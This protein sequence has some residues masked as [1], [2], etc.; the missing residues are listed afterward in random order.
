[1]HGGVFG[2]II[3]QA[4]EFADLDDFGVMRGTR[5]LV[6]KADEGLDQLLILIKH[7]P[8]GFVGALEQISTS[9]RDISQILNATIDNPIPGSFFFQRNPKMEIP[10]FVNLLFEARL[11]DIPVQIVAPVCPDYVDNY[12][13]GGGIGK[14]AEKVLRTFPDI[15]K[16]FARYGFET[17]LR[18]DIADVEAFDPAILAASSETTDSFLGKIQSTRAEIERSI[19]AGLFTLSS[20]D[21][22]TMT[23]LFTQAQFDYVRT[24]ARNAYEIL[25]ATEGK[26]ARVRDQLI[27]ERQRLGD[28]D[29][30]DQNRVPSLISYE[31]GGYAAYGEFVSGSALILTPD[32]MSAVPAYHFGVYRPDEFSPIIY[33]R[34]FPGGN[35][36]IT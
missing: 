12:Q 34:N 6:E 21:V 24:S 9:A 31:L 15:Q 23:E 33:L 10:Q 26:K 7:T 14:T 17:S 29:H 25:S 11:S 20:I 16:L 28:V 8:F 1:M 3:E 32:A 22:N 2:G 18:I 19:K 36:D 13:L 27:E 4:R 5:S 35:H 30:I